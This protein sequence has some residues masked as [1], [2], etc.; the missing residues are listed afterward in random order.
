MIRAAALLLLGAG[1][2]AAQEA[3]VT[4]AA[5]WSGYAEFARVSAYLDIGESRDQASEFRAQAIRQG[6]SPAIVDHQI[7]AQRDGMFL[8]VR[9]TIEDGDKMSRDLLERQM[10]LCEGLP[11][12]AD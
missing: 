2:A 5:L 9:A 12:S 10:Q 6:L 8:L 1:P 11:G 3:E 7:A 4:C